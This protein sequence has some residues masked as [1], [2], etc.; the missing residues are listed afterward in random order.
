[1]PKRHFLI[2]ALTDPR[3]GEIR[4]IGKSSSGL[5]RPQEHGG[6]HLPRDRSRKG[7][8]IR[9]L[10]K[11]G[12]S[13]GVSVLEEFPSNDGVDPAEI[14]WIAYGRSQGWDLTNLTDGGD[15][16][17]G[18]KMSEAGRAKLRAR[19]FSPETR[20]KIA[21]SKRGK[22]QPWLVAR[23]IA[24]RGRKA[25]EETRA[26]LSVARKGNQ[27]LLGKRWKLSDEAKAKHSVASKATWQRED[28]RKAATARMTPERLHKMNASRVS[29]LRKRQWAIADHDLNCL[30]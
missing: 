2:Y 9:A 5:A 22:K 11:D 15:G 23:N 10:Q 13:Y 7:D 21:A 25:S 14:R 3:T 1:M 4:Y 19:K 24:N 17:F 28:Y 26:K 6:R 30:A 27:H 12:L 20:E 29:N 18:R 16:C 8:W